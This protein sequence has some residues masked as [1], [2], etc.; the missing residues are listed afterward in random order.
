MDLEKITAI[1]NWSI[2]KNFHDVQVFLNFANYYRRFIENYARRTK[3]ITDFLIKIRNKRKISE[4]S[5]PDHANETFKIL[6]KYFQRISVLRIFDF[7]L[8]I[9]MEFDASKF[10]FGKILFQFFS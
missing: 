10:A 9:R 5:W 8:F 6:K 3:F 4:F 1:V 7:N 2:S